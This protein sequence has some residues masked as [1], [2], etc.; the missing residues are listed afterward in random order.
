MG[1]EQWATSFIASAG[2]GILFNAPRN[3]LI[4][5]G[6]TGMIGWLIF[7]AC[8]MAGLHSVISNL[9]AAFAVAAISHILAK[10]YKT[11][12]IVFNA[13]GI[14]PL[15]PG[16]LAYDAMRS[17]MEN[18]YDAAIR[19]GAEAFMISGAIAMGLVF[20]EVVN[21]AVRGTKASIKFKR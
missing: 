20:S 18:R 12:V 11:P 7:S 1:I 19:F 2:F 8:T 21:Q 13:C 14:I 3:S 5:C 10:F 9:A 17:I 4:Q 16:G 6:L 15:V